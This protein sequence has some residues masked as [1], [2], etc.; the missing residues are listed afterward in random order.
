MK[1]FAAPDIAFVEP[2]GLILGALVS[3]ARCAHAGLGTVVDPGVE[4]GEFGTRRQGRKAIGHDPQKCGAA[5]GGHGSGGHRFSSKLAAHGGRQALPDPH[6][7][8]RR[9]HLI[10][11]RFTPPTFR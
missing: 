5:Q 3:V 11:A 6:V 1:I 2:D 8:S 7:A 9:V 4:E 10:G